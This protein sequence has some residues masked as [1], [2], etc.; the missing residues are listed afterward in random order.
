MFVDGCRCY[1]FDVRLIL[2]SLQVQTSRLIHLKSGV[3]MGIN[4]IRLAV[5]ILA[6]VVAVLLSALTY[7]F[8]CLNSASH[9]LETISQRQLRSYQ[10][11]SELRQSSD[12]LTRLVRTYVVTGN[13][14]YE[15]QYMAVLDIR[16]GKVARPE[17]YHRIYW[18][19]VTDS[20]SKPRPDSSQ[21]VS[22]QDLMTQAK[23]AEGEF[24]KLK[25]A[26]AKSNGLVNLEVRAMNA[27]TGKFED[28]AGGS[29]RT[30]E[31]DPALAQGLVH[32]KDYHQFKAQIMKPIDEF[33]TLMETRTQ[34]EVTQASAALSRSYYQFMGLMIVAAICVALLIYFAQWQTR[35]ML[36]CKPQQL[37]AALGEIAAGN[38]AVTLPKADPASAVGRLAVTTANLRQL[39]QQ[40]RNEAQQVN[41]GVTQLKHSAD[42]IGHDTAEM[43][44]IIA[45]NVATVEELTVSINL[46]ADNSAEARDNI[47]KTSQISSSSAKA[48]EHAATETGRVQGAMTGVGDTMSDMAQR[49][50]E[51]SSIV[52]V[53][54]EIADQTNL[55]A[56]NAAIEAARAG[57]QG[58]GFAVVADEVRKLAERTGQATV[59]ISGMISA[60][61]ADTE[62]ARSHIEATQAT[63]RGSVEST[64]KAVEQI[65]AMRTNMDVA[66]ASMAQ[67]AE[68]TREQSIAVTEIAESAEKISIKTQ[69]TDAQVQQT[70]NALN[71]LQN[72]AD[73]LLAVVNRFRL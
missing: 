8:Y 25:E 59:E 32:G 20:Q 71:H 68:A 19:F 30:A 67:I 43:S 55:L 18:D 2:C 13:P 46:I 11:A 66:V 33:F 73:D 54:K 24:A 51:I 5:R 7:E 4:Q 37:D 12:D 48:V 16:N 10:L 23:F 6:V 42:Q 29:T 26:E 34:V 65:H 58:R 9:D 50:K 53:I 36:G 57:E 1:A 64:A 22:L 31:P 21:R 56:L 3:M 41:D 61:G 72:R 52:G 27:L 38:L 69:S 63:V 47:E 45:A 15:R 14:E 49:S 28:G 39:V 44:S 62:T 40:L 70:A 35:I 17:H 60:V